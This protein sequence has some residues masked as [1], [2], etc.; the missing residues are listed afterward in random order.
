MSRHWLLLPILLLPLILLSCGG[1]A[2]EEETEGDVLDTEAIQMVM[3]QNGKAVHPKYGTE[4]WFAYGAMAG[5]AGTP[6]NGVAQAYRFD[7]DMFV[8]TVQLNIAPAEDGVFYEAWLTDDSGED[9]VSAGHL[10]NYFGDARHQVLF[11]SERDLRD[12]LAVVVTQEMDDG[13][14]TPA[15]VVARGQ[16]K[17]TRR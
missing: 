17:P 11:E 4:Q 13:D 5:E 14:P 9:M 2:V 1:K 6:A 16:L 10:T 3:P 7:S 12:H 8:L 15:Q